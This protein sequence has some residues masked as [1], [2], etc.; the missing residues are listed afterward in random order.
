MSMLQK[1]N[2]QIKHCKSNELFIKKWNETFLSETAK[3]I[4]WRHLPL[5]EN[6][7]FELN[8]SFVFNY[9]SLVSMSRYQFVTLRDGFYGI[10]YFF[11]KHPKPLEK[12]ETTFLI[13][14]K[15]KYLIPVYWKKNVLLYSFESLPRDTKASTTIV[16]GTITNENFLKSSI[17]SKIDGLAPDDNK[18]ILAT[19]V[20]EKASFKNQDET[21]LT[22]TFFSEIYKRYGFDIDYKK[23]FVE[24]EWNA[25]DHTYSF[26]NL[27]TDNFFITYDYLTEFFSSKGAINLQNE[28]IADESNLVARIALS[29]F[30]NFIVEEAGELTNEIL[31]HLIELKKSSIPIN[32]SSVAFYEYAKSF[33][34]KESKD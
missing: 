14:K 13:P 23:S 19:Q 33:F 20:K 21:E 10:L 25:V 5:T 9:K 34:I 22:M 2:N 11:L 8:P 4:Y 27:D 31:K 28:P 12:M 15:F 32:Y 6:I 1:I 29:P 3:S 30:H 18:V 17:K 24:S 7:Y 26:V 16:F